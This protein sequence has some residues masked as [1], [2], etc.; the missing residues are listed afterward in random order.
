MRPRPE[1]RFRIGAAL[2]LLAAAVQA[3]I[4]LTQSIIDDALGDIAA[5]R[6]AAGN[7]TGSK[8]QALYELAM[9]ATALMDLLNQEIAL[10]GLEQQDL[11]ASAVASA[12]ELGVDIRWSGEHERYFYTGEAYAR[13]LELVPDGLN[14]ANS[15]F[16]LIET[17][18]YLGDAGDRDELDARI[19][20]AREYLQLY[21]DT[22]NAAR[23]AI[24]LAID[25]RDLWR[26]CRAAADAACAERSAALLREHLDAVSARY[27]DDK[28]GQMARALLARFDAEAA[29][30]DQAPGG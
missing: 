3:H 30:A 10:H 19:T 8:A 1:S 5:A 14:A 27:G 16:H 22:A 18:F 17:G 20:L 28:T 23:V 4:P 15:R 9:R 29:E 12:A 24:F 2:L 7:D 11:L 6:T 13:Y 21:P 25:Y 26:S